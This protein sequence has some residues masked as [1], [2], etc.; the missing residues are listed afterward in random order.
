MTSAVPRLKVHMTSPLLHRS[1]L[2]TSAPL[3]AKQLSSLYVTLWM[4]RNGL[5]LRE[6]SPSSE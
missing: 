3:L 4:S 5:A 6:R 1:Q 2:I